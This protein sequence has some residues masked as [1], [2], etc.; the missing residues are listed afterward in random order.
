[1]DTSCFQHLLSFSC[2]S[3]SCSYSCCSKH[4]AGYTIATPTRTVPYELL[5]HGSIRSPLRQKEFLLVLINHAFF[6]LDLSS[7]CQQGEKKGDEIK[8]R[9]VDS[10]V[11]GE[12]ICSC[13]FPWVYLVIRIIFVRVKL[14]TKLCSVSVSPCTSRSIAFLRFCV[15]NLDRPF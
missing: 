11:M 14:R 6:F 10:Q 9:K 13:F 2:A 8:Q 4:R 15:P 1:M 12:L 7:S 5:G 3:P